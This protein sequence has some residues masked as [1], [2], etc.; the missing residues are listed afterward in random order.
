M[1][2]LAIAFLLIAS[3]ILAQEPEETPKYEDVLFVEGSLPNVPDSSTIATKL[4]L[5]LQQTPASVGVITDWLIEEQ[6]S[7]LL[8]EALQNV[9]GVNVQTHSGVA[10]FFVVR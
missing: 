8:G 5:P 6:G 9:S 10:D 1:K 3:P 2:N 4:P 7:S